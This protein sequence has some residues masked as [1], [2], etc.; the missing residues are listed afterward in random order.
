MCRSASIT[1]C[2]ARLRKC[3]NKMCLL[4]RDSDYCYQ[5]ND[6]LIFVYFI[7]NIVIN[8]FSA[9]NKLNRLV[10]MTHRLI[11]LNSQ[12][13]CGIIHFSDVCFFQRSCLV[14]KYFFLLQFSNHTEWFASIQTKFWFIWTS[15]DWQPN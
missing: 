10:L 14:L 8:I 12:A 3:I 5:K 4:S 6:I 13:P 7:Y 2:N 15:L 1:C 11:S 9:Q